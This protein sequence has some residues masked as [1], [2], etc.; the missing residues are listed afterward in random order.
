MDIEIKEDGKTVIKTDNIDELLKFLKA[1]DKRD[2][3]ELRPVLVIT[4]D[5]PVS[6]GGYQRPNVSFGQSLVAS[7]ELSGYRASDACFDDKTADLC[8]FDFPTDHS[9]NDPLTATNPTFSPPS[10]GFKQLDESGNFSKKQQR[11]I[12]GWDSDGDAENLRIMRTNIKVLV[13]ASHQ[14]T[15][16]YIAKILLPW[17]GVASEELPLFIHHGPD[18]GAIISPERLAIA[19]DRYTADLRFLF[20]HATNFCA[21]ARRALFKIYL[22]DNIDKREAQRAL[23][24]LGQYS[25]EWAHPLLL[26]VLHLLKA[27]GQVGT[28]EH[29]KI[30]N[31]KAT[32]YSFAYLYAEGLSIF[33]ATSDGYDLVWAGT[34]AFNEWRCHIGKALR[35]GEQEPNAYSSHF[36]HLIF[37]IFQHVASTG[38]LGL[39]GTRIVLSPWGVK[40]LELLGPAT[41]DP[42]LLLRWRSGSEMATLED[43]EPMDNWLNSTFELAKTSVDRFFDAQDARLFEDADFLKTE[44]LSTNRLSILGIY[45]SLTA[46][47]LADSEIVAEITRVRDSEQFI[48]IAERYRGLVYDP[49]KM[50]SESQLSGLWIGVPLT[51]AYESP[52]PNEPGWLKDTSKEFDEAV[53]AIRTTAPAIGRRLAGHEPRI[54][55]NL[56][57]KEK[58]GELRSLKWKL[59][60]AQLD[61]IRPI[62]LGVAS[63]IDLQGSLP[64]ALRRRLG[65]FTIKPGVPEYYD[66]INAFCGLGTNLI[67]TTCGYFVGLYD[68][69]NGSFYVD[70]EIH[71]DRVEKF[72]FW[73][74]FSL[75]SL[76]AHFEIDRKEDGY[77]TVLKDGSAKRI[78]VQLNS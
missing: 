28:H 45:I 12:A 50:K 63:T 14:L 67:T 54:I 64:E 72:G 17:Q 41:N 70:R 30:L 8:N 22:D 60:S 7:I 58:C 33:E 21:V 10:F 74:D 5:D 6:N 24:Y 46:A 3:E 1:S 76:K 19:R 51:V 27:T 34:G 73:K 47:D 43:I 61:D 15:D 71:P 35:P 26:Q 11:K 75:G 36:T 42:D 4:M 29:R 48:P 40:F 23:P 68:E 32:A 77:W 66:G 44:Q 13:L 20:N 52:F 62:I 55:H 49:P 69:S 25:W 18:G 39:N 65:H 31:Q 37:N 78:V 16:Q 9:W 59:A 38:L 56:P 57:T 2:I 53:E